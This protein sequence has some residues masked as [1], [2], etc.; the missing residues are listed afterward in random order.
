MN[1]HIKRIKS[2]RIVGKHAIHSEGY[3]KINRG[4]W[5]F[6][7]EGNNIKLPYTHNGLINCHAKTTPNRD[8]LFTGKLDNY[9]FG[10]YKASDWK[11]A[12]SKSTKQRAV[13]NY[14]ATKRLH[15]SGLGP[16]P[17]GFCHVKNFSEFSKNKSCENF[18]IL[19]DN[20]FNLPQKKDASK[21]EITDAGVHL[22]LIQSCYRQQVN[23]YVIDLN[24]VCG[25]LPIDAKKEIEEM[26]N[27]LSEE[28]KSIK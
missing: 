1:I 27:W 20:V 4:L 23:G 21:E 17:L 13:E 22:D 2:M 5:N 15:A 26:V 24:S 18:G 19:V 8:D 3:S 25:V 7:L 9:D 11:N 28:T 16:K 14:I 6:Y 12:L 10:R